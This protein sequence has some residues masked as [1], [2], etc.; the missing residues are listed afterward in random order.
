MGT[1]TSSLTGRPQAEAE[2][3]AEWYWATVTRFL[4]REHW[5]VHTAAA[6]ALADSVAVAVAQAE[7]PE[8]SA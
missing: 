7:G 2:T 6:L 5:Q 8:E 4:D 1:T 3:A